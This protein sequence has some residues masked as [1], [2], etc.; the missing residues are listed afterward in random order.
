MSDRL[1]NLVLGAQREGPW[2]ER[3]ETGPEWDEGRRG[4]YPF[5]V[6]LTINNNVADGRTGQGAK[7]QDKRLTMVA[8]TKFQMG[9]RG[10]RECYIEAIQAPL[11]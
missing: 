9:S 7:M 1:D 3:P 6:P 4:V 5:P 2:A 8:E 10:E 11:R